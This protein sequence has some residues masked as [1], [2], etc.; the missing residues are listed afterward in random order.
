MKKPTPFYFITVL[1][2]ILSCNS[3]TKMENKESDSNMEKLKIT[4]EQIDHLGITD[5]NHLSAASKR[6]LKWPMDL[7]NEWF[8]QFGPLK[9][10]KG[11]LA[12]EEGVV[13]RDPSA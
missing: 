1:A 3:P 4:E 9:P 10:L 13:R 2:F 5:V 12:Y 8:I 7:G 11:D 6:A